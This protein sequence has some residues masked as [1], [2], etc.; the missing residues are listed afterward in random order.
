MGKSIFNYRRPSLNRMLG[1]SKAKSSFTRHTGGAVLRNPKVLFT[2]A[3]RRIK[4]RV[5]YYSPL[6]KA[7]RSRHFYIGPF[8][9]W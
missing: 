7:L 6:M 5:G 1:I 9:L 2:N 3:D 8:K 4:R